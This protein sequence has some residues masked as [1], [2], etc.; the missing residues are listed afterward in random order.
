M[1]IHVD[2]TGRRIL[3][4]GASSGLGAATCRAVVE[5]G[6]SVA[7]LARRKGRLAELEAELGERAVG[8]PA[9]VTDGPGL[10]AAVGQS[11]ERLGGLDGVV[12]VAGKSMVG[13][14]A[15]GTPQLWRELVELNFLGSLSAVHYGL[16]HFANSGRRDVVIVGSVAALTPMPGTGLYSATKSALLAACESM[17][18]ELA[19]EGI[20]VGV[21]MPGMFDTEGLT[22]EGL[23]MDGPFP[24][25]EFPVMTEGT[26]PGPAYLVGDAITFMLA[27]PEGT[28]INELVVRPTGQLNP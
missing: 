4:T 12:S 3:V 5:C 26:V 23:V 7:M 15:T 8:V 20:G 16:K 10:E 14:I 18:H 1:S 25:N 21:V 19:P 22:L 9:D 6:G 11:A 17:R 28:T 13:A 24:T 2:L 27:Q